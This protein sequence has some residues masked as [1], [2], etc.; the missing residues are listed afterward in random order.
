MFPAGRPESVRMMAWSLRAWRLFGRREHGSMSVELVVIAPGLIG[1]LLLVGAGGR[2]VEAQ[3]HLDGAARD[4]AR[5]A[6][7]ALSPAQASQLALQAAQ[8]DLGVTS[9]CAA[10]SVQALVAG[11]PAIGQPVAAG[12]DVTVT[13]Q[14]AV[15]MSPF[16]ALGF[17]PT[18]VF[19]GRAVAPLDTFVERNA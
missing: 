14:C 17:N 11:F 6:S 1:L 4:A 5:A 10:G 12:D 16:T 19:S 18:M 8:A 2:V 9:W 3:G 15:N 7:L 13:V